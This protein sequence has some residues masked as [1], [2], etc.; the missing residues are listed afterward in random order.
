MM[1]KLFERVPGTRKLFAVSVLLG[2]LGGMLIILEAAWL[3]RI[4]DRVFLGGLKL[5]PLLPVFGVLLL[6]IGLRFV[7]HT[8]GEYAASQMALRIKRDL[9]SRLLRKLTELGP[10]YV[11][12]E[13]SGELAGTVYEGVEQLE[14]YL[15]KYLPQMALSMLIPAAVFCVVAGLDWFSAVVLAV[16]LPLLVLFMILVGMTAKAKAGK[17]FAVLSRLGGHFMDVLR[18]LPTLKLFNRS[19]A[20]IDIISRISEDY[21][22]TTM[23]TLRLAFLSAFVMELFATL[24]TAIVAVFLGLRLIEGQIGFEWAFLVLLLT[25]EYY[26]PIRALGTQF[27]AST[28]GMAAA[29]RIL[30]ILEM[31]PGTWTEHE[32]AEKL[33]VCAFGYRIEF[34]N[35][36][37][38]YPGSKQPALAGLTF[39]IEPEERMAVIGPTGAGKSTLLDLLQGFIRPSEGTIRVNGRDIGELSIGWWREQLSVVAQN[40]RLYHG[41]VRDNLLLG[42]PHASPREIEA[43]VAAA[44]AE[45]VYR[46]PDGLDTRLGEMVRLSG[47]QAQRIAIARALLADAPVLLLDEPTAGLDLRHEAAVRDAL[48]ALLKGR[49]SIMVA[50][51]LD[52]VRKADRILVLNGGRI[53]ESG[54][55]AE[56]LAADGL[57]AAML[58]AGQLGEEQET[59]LRHE[60]SA[61]E[62]PGKEEQLSAAAAASETVD[63]ESP[64]PSQPAGINSG[65]PA[66]SRRSSEGWQ[67]LARML[68]FVR[69]YRGRTALAALLGFATIAANVGLMGT[70]GY[71]IAKAAL[72]PET[73]LLLWIPI[74]GVRFFGIARGV[75]RYLERLVAHDLT[76]RILHRVRV[77]LYRSLE[78]EGVRLLES[79][80]SGDI[81]GALISDVEQLQNLYLRVLAPPLV[82]LLTLILGFGIMAWHAPGLG[83]ILAISMLL[84]GTLVPWLSHRLAR[85]YGEGM[86]RTRAALYTETAELMNGLADFTIFGRN[87]QRLDVIESIQEEADQYQRGHNRL[88]AC[89]SGGMLAAAHLTMWLILLYAVHLVGIG[90]LPGIAIPALAMMALACFEAVTPLPAA[91]QQLGQTMSSASRLFAVADEC[92]AASGLASEPLEPAVPAELA[93]RVE[94]AAAV[95]APE[96]SRSIEAG[97]QADIR[98]L[99]FRYRPEEPYALRDI[100]FSLKKGRRTA[101]VG[102]SGA[103]KSTLLQVLLR[104]R[105][106]EEGSVRLGEAEL[107]EVPEELVRAQF[108]VVSQRVQLFNTTVGA[109]LR[110]GRQDA[111]DSE[112]VEAARRAMVHD[113]IAALPGGYRTV[114]GEQGARLSGGE[115]QRLALARALLKDA[116][117]VLFDEPSEGLD[118]ITEQALFRNMDGMLRDKALLWITHRLSGLERMDEIIV[119]QGGRICERGTH[120]ELLQRRGCYYQLWK[121]EREQDWQRVLDQ[122]GSGA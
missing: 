114:I 80:R 37:Y 85:S 69:P 66:G 100:T 55:P 87:G 68:Q 108:A 3:A 110:L 25:P 89:T 71:L 43:A 120:S 42:A 81:L 27:H 93:K 90:T 33:P 92:G 23:G 67:T 115:R 5:G 79:R 6:W 18:G 14:N 104:L 77:W 13:R 41:T 96:A 121:L 122:Y 54:A 47:G 17:Q 88:G 106:Y 10:A 98:G 53:A 36:G 59:G 78:P 65:S 15:A 117:A 29:G 40:A 48:N 57:Y 11:K 118:P 38:T 46:L 101:V 64:R 116:P 56:L 72:R 45:F 83:V 12:G 35:V 119:L 62:Q 84:T 19:R 63:Q 60:S 73:V 99:S 82:A 70:S 16:T 97:W 39:T 95:S 74:V 86:V 2:T 52:T 4:A 76:F 28:N 103:G 113:T 91:F 75:L 8:A 111:S 26:S 44:K 31:E 34:D 109:N 20:Q 61:D 1:K 21:R 58:K 50:H 51:R 112:L 49:T 24:S 7:V 9:R 22:K 107:R 102:E 105:P 32:G 30:D 94:P